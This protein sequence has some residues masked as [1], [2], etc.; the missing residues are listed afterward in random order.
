MIKRNNIFQKN[1]FKTKYENICSS[2][3]KGLYFLTWR[4]PSVQSLEKKIMRWARP[5]ATFEC[6]WLLT[7]VASFEVQCGKMIFQWQSTGGC[8]WWSSFLKHCWDIT[9]V[10]MTRKE[11][12]SGD[13]FIVSIFGHFVTGLLDPFNYTTA[14]SVSM[15]TRVANSWFL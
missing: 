15:N 9:I 12:S 13:T 7:S 2:L 1:V 5:A 3:P 10:F 8:R 6:Y 14:W 4:T 11:Q